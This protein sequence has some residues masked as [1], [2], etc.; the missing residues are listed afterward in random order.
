M[1]KQYACPHLEGID[2]S[3]PNQGIKTCLHCEDSICFEDLQDQ[4]KYPTTTKAEK[5][6]RIAS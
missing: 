3:N 2:S 4:N 6:P 1:A 5:T